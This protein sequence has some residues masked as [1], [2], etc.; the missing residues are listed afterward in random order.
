MK[1]FALALLLCAVLTLTFV[2]H[3][4]HSTISIYETGKPPSEPLTVAKNKKDDVQR[5]ASGRLI[6]SLTD[7]FLKTSFVKKPSPAQGQI[8]P[9]ATFIVTTTMDNGSNTSPTPNS[10]RAAILNANNSVGADTITFNIPGSGVRTITPPAPLPTITSPVTIDGYSQ[11]GA[12]PNTL[13]VGNNGVLLI[14]LNGT[15]AGATPGLN[16]TASNCVVRGLVIN[17]FFDSGIGLS[18]NSFNRIEGNFIGTNAAGT[19]PLPNG[20]DGVMVFINSSDNTIGGTTP[21]ARNGISGNIRHGI[22]LEGVD[23]SRNIIQGNYTGTNASATA[24][25]GNGGNGVL[26]QG[27]TGTVIGG[28]SVSAPNLIAGSYGQNQTG[29]IGN[30]ILFINANQFLV[31]N[32]YVGTNQTGTLNMGNARNGIVIE[33]DSPQG[34]SGTVRDV[35]VAFNGHYGIAYNKSNNRALLVPNVRVFANGLGGILVY[36]LNIPLCDPLY[37]IGFCLQREVIISTAVVSNNSL[38]ISGYVVG[39]ETVAT[40][41]IQSG[42][43]S[44]TD[45]Q[46]SGSVINARIAIDQHHQVGFNSRG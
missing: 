12:S 22:Q 43:Y 32:N 28:A 29:T 20:T 40:V 34:G 16:I 23:T 18:T 25:I 35:A 14:E 13:P 5:K 4:T 42:A 44:G 10:L 11:P 37:D 9:Q 24:A 45:D 6:N 15:S 1:F 46:F 31:E 36:D 3:V 21:A 19:A 27:T 30:G 33:D 2:I 41:E 7:S 39:P 17:R 8:E 38:T 26:V